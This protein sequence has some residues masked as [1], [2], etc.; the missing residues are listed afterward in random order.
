MYWPAVHHYRQQNSRQ[1]NRT[2][3]FKLFKVYTHYNQVQT[4]V[5]V[6]ICLLFKIT[7]AL[8]YRNPES[9]RILHVDKIMFRCSCSVVFMLSNRFIMSVDKET[10]STWDVGWEEPAAA[11]SYCCATPKI[12]IE[13]SYGLKYSF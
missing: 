12:D 3:N 13:S 10:A 5:E 1:L 11:V 2:V 9:S 8:S 6:N 4:T 7:K